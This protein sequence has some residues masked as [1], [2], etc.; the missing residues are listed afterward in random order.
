MISK[1]IVSVWMLT[2]VIFLSYYIIAGILN[3]PDSDG[4]QF[5]ISSVALLPFVLRSLIYI[6]VPP[7]LFALIINKLM[8]NK[9]NS[10]QIVVAK[11]I[12]LVTIA[13][14]FPI[15]LYM[16]RPSFDV[17]AAIIFEYCIALV[18]SI[19]IIN[20]QTLKNKGILKT[21]GLT[22]FLYILFFYYFITAITI[23]SFSQ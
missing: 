23:C 12:L 2:I 14:G 11:N 18:I 7:L 3:S 19:L 4:S 1:Q 21:W 5:V 15:F 20:Y 10:K 9:P 13:F 17:F 6:S 16:K 22:L 8:A